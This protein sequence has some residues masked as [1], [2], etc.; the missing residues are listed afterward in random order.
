MRRDLFASALSIIAVSFVIGSTLPAVAQRGADWRICGQVPDRTAWLSACTRIIE[1]GSREPVKGRAMAYYY[2]AA[3]KGQ[4]GDFA[5]AIRDYDESIRIDPAYSGAYT[6]RGAA[7]NELGEHD[8]AIRDLDEAIRLDPKDASAYGNR[9]FAYDKK[10]DLDRAIRDYDEAVRL[11]RTVL[12]LGNRA[13]PLTEKGQY[14]RALRD[15]DEALRIAPNEFGV[16]AFR[17][18]V[19]LQAGRLDAAIRDLDQAI[20]LQPRLADGFSTRGETYRRQGNLDRALADVNEA[21]RL[22]SRSTLAFTSRG[23]IYEERGEPERAAADFKAALASPSA[24]TENRLARTQARERL[25]ALEAAPAPRPAAST[26]VVASA[27]PGRRIALVIGNAAY[28]GVP[29]LDNPRRDAAAIAAALKA[30]GFQ[31]VRLE[32]DLAREKL[33]DA[34]RGFAREAASADWAVI[35]YAGHGLEVGGTNYLVPIDAKLESDRDVQYEAVALEQVLG[36]VD[37]AKKLRLVILD[38]CRDNP[39]VSRMKR[40]VA[41]RSIGR[42]LA[43]VEPDGGTLVA[44]AAKSGEIALDGSGTNSPFVSALVKH[45]PTPGLEIGKLFRQVRDDVL[46]ATGRKQEPFVYGSLPGEDFFFVVG[47]R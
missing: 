25:A 36:A 11:D 6:N 15:L 20:R 21:I 26:A 35:Y 45:L 44:Y 3:A 30:V 18:F 27:V 10:G 37:G 7:L 38:A 47:A 13:H 28:R 41:S 8:R 34:L 46:T 2:R 14:D 39:F 29:A 22:D 19:H 24:Q 12:N 16:L 9:A 43:R 1:R 33:I 32:G 4:M 23:L 31:T 40:M 42:G 5:D 17:G